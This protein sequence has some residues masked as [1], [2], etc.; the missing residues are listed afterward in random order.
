[1]KKHSDTHG[2]GFFKRYQQLSTG[3]KE[4]MSILEF[5]EKMGIKNVAKIL[6]PVKDG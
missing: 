2:P 1:M 6:A 5:F 3:I 4:D